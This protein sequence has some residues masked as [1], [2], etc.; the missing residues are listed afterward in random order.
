MD[1]R[2][3]HPAAHGLE[4]DELRRLARELAGRRESAYAEVQDEIATMKAEL[5]RRA[6]AIAERERELAEL[7]R[8]L[9]AG[10]LAGELAAVKRAVEEAE[11]ERRLAAAERERL[12]ER[13]QR[14]REVEKELAARRRELDDRAA[15]LR[16]DTMSMPLG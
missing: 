5:R 1:K 16:G 9:G 14:I 6:E 12:D 10:G 15:M 7:E 8:R 2:R 11:A 3:R 13:E 4:L